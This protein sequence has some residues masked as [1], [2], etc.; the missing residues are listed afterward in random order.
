MYQ[1]EGG[2]GSELLIRDQ[3][4]ENTTRLLAY[5]WV[6]DTLEYRL[7]AHFDG[8]RIEWEQ[9]QVTVDR[10][11]PEK[12]ELVLRCTYTPLEGAHIFNAGQSHSRSEYVLPEDIPDVTD[13]VLNSPHPEMVV[14]ALCSQMQYTDTARIQPYFTEEAWEAATQ[15]QG[16]RCG[17]AVTSSPLVHVRVTSMDI[18]E[19]RYLLDCDSQDSDGARED[20]AVV[21]AAVVCEYEDASNN[22]QPSVLCTMVREEGGW[23][24]A[25]PCSVEGSGGT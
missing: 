23:R 17:C 14:V 24:F 2:D 25:G 16:G 1:E 5:Q 8:H 10:Y 22:T 13:R 19:N 20:R 15:S 7:L 9:D 3:K 12:A 21:T 6:S 18:V 4:G 11:T